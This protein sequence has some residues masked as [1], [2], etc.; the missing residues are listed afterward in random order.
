MVP[1]HSSEASATR[2][3]AFF[4]SQSGTSGA[5]AGRTLNAECHG[6][7]LLPHNSKNSNKT[8]KKIPIPASNLKTL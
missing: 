4:R 5:G 1:K 8:E 3:E 2:T 7:F 6:L